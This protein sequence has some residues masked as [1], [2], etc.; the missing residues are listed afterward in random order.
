M[1]VIQTIISMFAAWLIIATP[2]MACC[3]TGHMDKAMPTHMTDATETASCH[4]DVEAIEGKPETKKSP[5]KFCSSCDDCSVSPAD[6][7]DITPA[8]NVSADMEILAIALTS[9]EFIASDIRIPDSTAPPRKPTLP[10]D[11][12]LFAT[13]SLLI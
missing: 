5:E 3:V 10:I 13:D 11:K 9:G 7:G 4:Q 6:V 1:R 2:A 12:L 8:L